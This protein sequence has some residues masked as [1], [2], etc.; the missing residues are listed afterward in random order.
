MYY[1]FDCE[2]FNLITGKYIKTKA[3]NEQ[4]IV[5]VTRYLYIYNRFVTTKTA[6]TA[7]N[8]LWIFGFSWCKIKTNEF[9][10]FFIKIF[11]YID[12]GYCKYE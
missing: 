10:F 1:V 2:F 6:H 5:K 7:N 9:I 11:F 8:V 4:M 12:S 3:K